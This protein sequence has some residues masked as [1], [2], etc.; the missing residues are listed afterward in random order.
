MTRADH[1][2]HLGVLARQMRD[3]NRAGCRRA[4]SGQVVAADHRQRLA[5]VRVEQK[6]GRLVVG[7]P[8]VHIAGPVAAGF[9]T[10]HQ[11]RP[12]KA[13]LEAIERIGM[14]Q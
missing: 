5:G 11:P 9:E 13:R 3:R 10:E 1:A 14:A 12:V 7:Q 2:Q 8:L 4:H 6:H